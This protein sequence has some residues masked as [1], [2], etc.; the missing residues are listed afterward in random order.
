MLFFPHRRV[1]LK[2]I[3]RAAITSPFYSRGGAEWDDGRRRNRW[4]SV[5]FWCRSR[6]CASP[7][8]TTVHHHARYAQSARSVTGRGQVAHSHVRCGSPVV[9]RRAHR[10]ARDRTTA[11]FGQYHH[12]PT[13]GPARP[14]PHPPQLRRDGAGKDADDRGRL[15]RLRR[16]RHIALRSRVEDRGGPLPGD[17]HLPDEPADVVAAGE[18]R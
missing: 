2:A 14:D 13:P 4:F 11:Q 1:P 3:Q 15:R 17:R 7:E 6:A 18:P 5:T 9:G 12:R 8:P 10:A 16:R